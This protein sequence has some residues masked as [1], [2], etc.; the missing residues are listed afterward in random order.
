MRIKVSDLNPN[1]FRNIEK[2][3][4]NRDKVKALKA[5]IE[6]TTFWDNVLA[7]P[8]R[9]HSKVVVNYVLDEYGNP[10]I[11]SEYHIVVGPFAGDAHGAGIYINDGPNSKQGCYE[12]PKFELA[13]GHHRHVALKE[14]GIEEVDIPIR[15][16]DDATMLRI[17]ANENLSDWAATPG[18]INETVFAAKEFLD[19]ELGKASDIN[20]VAKS[21][22]VMFGSNSQFQQCK[23]DGVGHSIIKKFLGDNWS[24]HMIQEA[25]AVYRSVKVDEERETRKEKERLLQIELMEA[26]REEEARIAEE[27]EEEK[28]RVMLERQQQRT[29]EIERS[30]A[31]AARIAKEM[32]DSPSIDRDAYESFDSQ[33]KAIEFRKAVKENKIPKAV[34]KDLAA[35]IKRKGISGPSISDKVRQ[36]AQI[37]Q[38]KKKEVKEKPKTHLDKFAEEIGHDA[39]ALS[40]KLRRILPNVDIIY[41]ED[42]KEIFYTYLKT[43]QKLIAETLEKGETDD[44]KLSL[45]HSNS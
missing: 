34:Q 4:I 13:Y 24:K 27:K 41:S 6:Q 18:V 37:L 5:S 35:E 10:A 26:Q 17:M 45:V 9:G 14:L 33:N 30:K 8:L 36:T 40:N 22:H 19:G 20:H 29:L 43:L 38:P 42:S 16:L 2:Y 11:E 1:P 25:L 44:D 39:T 3:E 21:I 7:R 23:Q 28:L 15:D 12:F 32:E 31:E